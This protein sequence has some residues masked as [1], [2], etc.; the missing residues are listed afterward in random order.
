L[1]LNEC[2]S[3]HP[4]GLKIFSTHHDSGFVV[5]KREL[6]LWFFSQ[7]NLYVREIIIKPTKTA[8]MENP[9]DQ[10]TGYGIVP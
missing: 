7:D 10:M 3:Q 5:S 4:A 1:A 6:P 9:L 8:I 2:L